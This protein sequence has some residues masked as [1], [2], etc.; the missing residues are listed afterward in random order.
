MLKSG[1]IL[2]ILD[3]LNGENAILKFLEVNFE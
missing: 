3:F 1:A 2:N